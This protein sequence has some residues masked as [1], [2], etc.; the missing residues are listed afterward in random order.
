[1]CSRLLHGLQGG[2]DENPVAGGIDVVNIEWRIR[3][4]EG[5][6]GVIAVNLW[7]YLAGVIDHRE[8]SH[9]RTQCAVVFFEE[10]RDS[11]DSYSRLQP[12]L[13][14]RAK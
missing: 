11:N 7:L 3:Y 4:A 5:A 8:L 14:V 9:G 6:T 1:M 12:V 2:R 13:A 10:T